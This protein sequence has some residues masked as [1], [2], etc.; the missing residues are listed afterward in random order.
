MGLWAPESSLADAL[1]D[2]GAH[3]PTGSDLGNK[4]IM[5][6]D[7]ELLILILILILEVLIFVYLC[8]ILFIEPQDIAFC[9]WVSAKYDESSK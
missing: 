1:E 7:S 9:A 4:Y 6:S 5:A 8:K 2:S 3:R